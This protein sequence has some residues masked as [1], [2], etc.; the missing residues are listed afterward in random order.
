MVS[1]K[2]ITD[3]ASDIPAEYEAEYE[4]DIINFPLIVGDQT[5]YERIDFQNKEEFYE[6][7][8]QE[9]KIPSHSQITQLY[10][11]EKFSEVQ[12]EGYQDVIYIAINSK[13]SN[14]YNAALMAR[15][16]FY[17]NHPECSDFHIHIVD[18]KTYTYAYGY[19]VVEAAKKVKRGVPVNEVLAFLTDWFNCVEIYAT[20]YTLEFAKKS[21]RVSSTAA[22]VGELLGLKPIITFIDGDN[23]A[24]EK[25]RGDKAVVP[26]LIKKAKARMIPKT[27]YFILYGDNEDEK[28]RMVKECEKTFGYPP[29]E[30]FQIGATIAINIGPSVIA[31]VVKGQPKHAE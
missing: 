15:E 31:I 20:A 1:V 25:V 27:P 21:G 24:Q 14:T 13:G 17:Q 23:A 7:L 11:E 3:S 26:T 10:F 9:P 29:T 28:N 6:R 18:S 22:F 16:Q 30:V 4:I 19:A 5:Y 8:R 12:K 2:I